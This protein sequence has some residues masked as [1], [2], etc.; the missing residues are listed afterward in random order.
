[1]PYQYKR[2]PLTTHRLSTNLALFLRQNP[3]SRRELYRRAKKDYHWRSRI[4]HGEGQ[5]VQEST[6][7]DL[8]L[9]CEDW[10]R[11]AL[12]KIVN[13]THLRDAFATPRGRDMLFETWLLSPEPD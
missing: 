10:L 5:S 6:W 7:A 2:E 8:M 3:E 11:E 13:S 4:V 1:M 9:R 12:K